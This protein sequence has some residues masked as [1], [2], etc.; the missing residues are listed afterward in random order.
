VILAATSAF[1]LQTMLAT[2][3][4]TYAV[5]LGMPRS[6][7]VFAHAGAS[8]ISIV[9]VLFMGRL[10]D[11]IGRKPLMIT[12][13]VLFIAVLPGVFAL[14]ATG[15]AF[16]VFLAFALGIVTQTL[17]YGPLAAFIGERFGTSSRYTGASM[18]YQTATLL[19]G[20]FTPIIL[21][22]LYGGAGES[23]TPVIVY[24]SVIAA[25]SLVTVAFMPESKNL[26]L[27]ETGS[28]DDA[29]TPAPAA[30]R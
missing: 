19:G 17:L 13:N 28:S 7:V 27:T 11:R 6:E 23:L 16:L 20:G 25:I 26:S 9:S 30:T 15:N 24:L 4:V 8:A 18:G 2:F 29:A 5:S 1:A 14:L 21:A 10:S 12:G 3:A 22:N